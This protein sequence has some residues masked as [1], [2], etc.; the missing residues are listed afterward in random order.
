VVAELDLGGFD[1]E[2]AILS[3]KTA[4]VEL[5]DTILAS[6]DAGAY[7][8]DWLPVFHRLRKAS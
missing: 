6:S 5:L 3:G 2:L 1:D 4:N 8:A 7:P